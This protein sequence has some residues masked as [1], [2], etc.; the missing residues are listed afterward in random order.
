[1]CSSDLR[2]SDGSAADASDD[3][4]YCGL[5]SGLTAA[6]HGHCIYHPPHVVRAGGSVGAIRPQVM[7]SRDCAGRLRPVPVGTRKL[8]S[9]EDDADVK[10]ANRR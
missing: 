9:G 1:M 7:M 10:L 8:V 3:T 5:A 4:T 6:Q 2:R